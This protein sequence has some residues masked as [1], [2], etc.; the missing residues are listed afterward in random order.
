MNKLIAMT[1]LVVFSIPSIAK[2][3]SSRIEYKCHVELIGGKQVI[4]FAQINAQKNKNISNVLLGKKVSA[5]NSAKPAA[6]YKIYECVTSDKSFAT[7]KAQ[8]ME[9]TTVR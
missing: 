8:K 5:N 2:P 4:Y 6:I 1:A 9:R 3:A 7:T